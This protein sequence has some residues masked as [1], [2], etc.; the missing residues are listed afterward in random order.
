MLLL[1]GFHFLLGLFILSS[2]ASRD[3]GWDQPMEALPLSLGEQRVLRAEANHHW[4]NRQ[5]REYLEEALAKLELLS[6]S[7]PKDA[8]L[9]LFLARG[10]F[11]LADAHLDNDD[12]RI[13]HYERGASFGEKVLYLVPAFKDD[14]IGGA[15]YEEA[16]KKTGPKEVDAMYWIAMSLKGWS[17]LQGPGTKYN[18][19]KRIMALMKRVERLDPNFFF[20][21][22]PRFKGILLAEDDD[23]KYAEEEFMLAFKR[24]PEYLGTKVSMAQYYWSKKKNKQVFEDTLGEVLNSTQDKHPEIGPENA[25]EKKKAEKLLE[26]IEKIF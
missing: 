4:K 15:S 6:S 22:V 25:L 10:N 20:G 23:L 17:D 26:N 3:L 16:L 8:R 7:S 11:L 5:H 18:E 9:F 13:R 12:M 1:V 14:I 21:A 24:A 2:C 19:A